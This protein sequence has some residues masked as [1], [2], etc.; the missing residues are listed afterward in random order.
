MI[1]STIDVYHASL[2]MG[3]VQRPMHAMFS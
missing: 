1:R 3:H 2:M